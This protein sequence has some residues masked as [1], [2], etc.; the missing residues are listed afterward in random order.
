MTTDTT[1]ATQAAAQ[2]AR[3]R[4]ARRYMPEADALARSMAR[5]LRGL[6]ELDDLIQEARAA[7][8]VAAA[9]VTPGADP[10][11]YLRSSIAGAL[12]RYVRDRV[13]LVRVPR[14]AHEA[15]GY[16][17]GHDSLD[18]P[19]HE[20]GAAFLDLLEAPEPEEAAPRDALA[21]EV[22]QMAER[23]PAADAAAL[24]LLVM[25]GRSIR[26]AA[27]SLGVAPMTASRRRDRAVDAIR[28]ALGA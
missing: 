20:G 3:D 15:G 17:L 12:R 6:A 4:I 22:A 10:L 9:R 14:H 8:V 19:M 2:A 13:R 11:P 16:P 21:A 18:A 23:L 7:L 26:E 1:Q 27:A 5:R 24:R 25:E 28:Y